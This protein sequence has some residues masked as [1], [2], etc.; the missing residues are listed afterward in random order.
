MLDELRCEACSSTA[1]ALGAEERRLLLTE[2]DGW[3]ML[4]RDGIPQLEKVY[5][6][7]KTISLLGLSQTK[8]L[9][10]QRKN[11]ITH[12]YYWSGGKV[13]V[14]WWSHSIKGLHQNDFI[15]AA[16]CDRLG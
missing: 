11:F 13:T 3:Q 5:T 6:F 9:S 8:F 15:C 7:K 12:P 16:K 4:E 2:L 10:W 14:T 1:V